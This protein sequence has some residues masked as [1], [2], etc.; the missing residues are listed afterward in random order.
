MSPAVTLFAAT[1]S[2]ATAFLGNG[3][4]L[5]CVLGCVVLAWRQ[6]FFFVT[7]VGA[8][9]LAALVLG[10]GGAGELA[11]WL[12]ESDLPP[13][14]APALAYGGIFAG[15]VTAVGMALGRWLPEQPV[16]NGTVL[17]RAVGVGLGA[18]A[19]LLLA[20]GILLGWSMA[21][22]PPRLALQPQ[23]LMFDAGSLA[24]RAA[25]RFVAPQ[26]GRRAE[27]LG[28]W[29]RF[30]SAK[31]GLRPTCSEP[32]VDTDQNC[33]RDEHE[34][35]LDINRDGAFTLVLPAAADGQGAPER[36]VPGM[37]DCYSMGSWL[38]V[39]AAHA[40]R[41][42]SPRETDVDVGALEAGLYQA[43]ATDPDPCDRITYAIKQTESDREPMLIVN[44][45]SGRVDLTEAAVQEV[46]PVYDFTLTA[47]DL[48]G[49][50]AEARVKVRV[51]NL[52]ESK[53]P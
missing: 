23:D 43:L 51:R 47:T 6:G 32:F 11:R 33:V 28:G 53:H 49:L 30:L 2:A 13:R 35:Y 44:P 5:A 3:I 9:F 24:L 39:M 45:E 20:A 12:I 15:V 36:W 27:L 50:V 4:V 18:V 29:Q 22:V 10:L 19:G 40:P 14:H 46:Q 31:P 7:L 1:V 16:W 42:T 17:G 25:S 8:G 48:S 52:P 34:R 37:L 26:P 41:L 38:D 21:A